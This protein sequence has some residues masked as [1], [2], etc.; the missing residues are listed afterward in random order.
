MREITYRLLC[1]KKNIKILIQN[2]KNVPIKMFKM[3]HLQ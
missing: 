3:F 1:K 2:N